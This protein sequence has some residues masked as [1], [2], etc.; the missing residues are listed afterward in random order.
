MKL[1]AFMARVSKIKKILA[2]VVL[3]T[4]APKA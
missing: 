4:E 2:Q 1:I 3:P